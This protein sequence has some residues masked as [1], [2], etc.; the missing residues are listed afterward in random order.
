MF[1]VPVPRI[2]LPYLGV[3][4]TVV[5]NPNVLISSLG[6]MLTGGQGELPPILVLYN[7]L[8]SSV[9]AASLGEILEEEKT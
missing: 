9:P 3:L 6:E 8:L 5:S 7:I 4:V 2:N 1:S